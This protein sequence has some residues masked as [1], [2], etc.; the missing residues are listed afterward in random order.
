M[1]ARGLGGGRAQSHARN[2]WPRGE[3]SEPVEQRARSVRPGQPVPRRARCGARSG[4][5]S[6]LVR[7]SELAPSQTA[8]AMRKQAM[9]VYLSPF[10]HKLSGE[11]S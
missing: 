9:P 3:I 7:E 1:T 6:E 8:V 10:L 5:E 4:H 11:T 2:T